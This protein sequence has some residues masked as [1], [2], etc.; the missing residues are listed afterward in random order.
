MGKRRGRHPE[1]ALSAVHVRQLKTA[2]RYADGN[3]LYLVVY[4]EHQ[5]FGATVDEGV[6]VVVHRLREMN[7]LLRDLPNRRFPWG[8]LEVKTLGPCTLQRTLRVL[9]ERL[10]VHLSIDVTKVVHHQ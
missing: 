4:V 8:M 3:G 2:G 5:P 1:K 7:K 10:F 6:P 9:P